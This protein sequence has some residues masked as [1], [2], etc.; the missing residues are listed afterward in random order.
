MTTVSGM[1][2]VTILVCG[3]PMRGDDAVGQAVVRALPAT[4]LQ[5]GEVCQVGG[6]MPDDLIAAG[7]PVIVVD[8]VHGLPA[9]TVVD[10][11][12]SALPELAEV[13]AT[14]EST[15]AIPLVTVL[16]IVERLAGELPEGRFIGVAAGTDLIGAPLS[17]P[18]RDAVDAC[19]ARLGHWIRT[20]AHPTT[21][22][23]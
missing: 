11:P 5:L 19:A 6:L 13:G 22:A 3:E 21:G 7:A 14:P 1:R 20:L 12:L 10:I 15:H 4:T 8:A 2:H 16:G 17:E 23:S 18:V 9:G